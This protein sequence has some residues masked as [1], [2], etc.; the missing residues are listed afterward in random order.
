MNK[1]RY[2]LL[3]AAALL[4]FQCA[5]ADLRPAG[6]F[7]ELGQGDRS[8]QAASVGLVWP[9][10]WQHAAGTGQFGGYTEAYVSRWSARGVDGRSNFGQ[11]G[12]APMFRFRPDAGRSPWFAEA[13]IGLTYMNRLF[14]TPDKQFS[15]RFN[16]RDVVGLGRSFGEGNRHELTLRLM[17]FS[18]GGINHPNPGQNIIGLR[19]G[20]LF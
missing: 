5:A 7:V 14:S 1:T 18:N 6:M 10:A 17:H 13:G 4:A 15:T 2:L 11:V 8:T 12:L 9:W 20:Y 16:F 3:P 19:Y